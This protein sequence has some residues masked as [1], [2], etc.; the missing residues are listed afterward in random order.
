MVVERI[1][2]LFICATSF[3]MGNILNLILTLGAEKKYWIMLLTLA[4]ST[5]EKGL[6]TLRSALKMA[7]FIALAF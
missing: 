4:K 5:R 7:H 3:R 2:I 1:F 6:N